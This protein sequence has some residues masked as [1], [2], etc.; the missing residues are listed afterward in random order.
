MVFTFGYL[1]QG[2]YYNPNWHGI[3]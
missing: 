3:A 2:V 1:P